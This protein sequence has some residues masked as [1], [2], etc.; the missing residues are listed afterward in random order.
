MRSTLVVR[1]TV[2]A[3]F[4]STVAAGSARAI[5]LEEGTDHCTTTVYTC[6]YTLV[7]GYN[8]P[9]AGNQVTLSLGGSVSYC[10]SDGDG[11]WDTTV[12]PGGGSTGY[13]NSAGYVRVTTA[14]WAA[15]DRVSPACAPVG[16]MG[17]K[18]PILRGGPGTT[19]LAGGG[20]VA[21]LPDAEGQQCGFES[22]CG[23]A[24]LYTSR[25]G[26]YDRPLVVAEGFDPK[27]KTSTPRTADRYWI[28][29][30]GHPDNLGG[31]P[32][33]LLNRLS[34]MGYDVWLVRPYK[35]GNNL[36]E[37]AA[38][39]A[40]AIARA[41]RHNGLNRKVIAFGYSLGGIVARVATARWTH[42]ASWRIS[43]G[44]QHGLPV[45]FILA[46]DAALRGAQLPND[47]QKFLW[48]EGMQGITNLDTCGAQQMAQFSY[49]RSAY[50]YL[51]GYYT[52]PGTHSRWEKFY[53][54][55]Q[56]LSF[57]NSTGGHS[58]Q[59]IYCGGGPAATR[60]GAYGDGW[61]PGVPRALLAQGTISQS[62]RCYGDS[63]DLNGDGFNVCKDTAG[64]WVP[65]AGSTYVKAVAK[66]SWDIGFIS[67]S[68]TK[69][70]HAYF[71]ANQS[72]PYFYNND[73]EPG[74]RHDTSV[75]AL[76]GFNYLS[77]TGTKWLIFDWELNAWIYQYAMATFMPARTAL[78]T[79]CVG[80]AAYAPSWSND[81]NATHR[82]ITDTPSNAGGGVGAASW[83]MNRI[84][85]TPV[86]AADPAMCGDYV[87]N[88][89]ESS[90][91][92]PSDCGA[93]PPQPY[94]GDGTC[95][96][97][98]GEDCYWCSDCGY[99]GGC[100]GPEIC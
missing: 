3:C 60:Q 13:T 20:M 66:V 5:P 71:V 6:D 31:W 40:Q 58:A 97:G 92:C 61:A 90:Y 16:R 14:I 98:Y 56:S 10:D 64:A 96:W 54:L 15:P 35:T 37:Q 53:H 77:Q 91:S 8:R 33:T 68:K 80:C 59:T 43:L 36:H 2:V 42:D 99:C 78:D 12:Y 24:R 57:V 23:S 39:Y 95:D 46:A 67:G 79:A 52:G 63:R 32:N 4:A 86:Q 25:D 100:G 27:E 81:F 34:T 84:G 41:S 26:V 75:Q 11:Q 88:G 48:D 44:L 73:L 89:P 69:R 82:R 87:C 19:Y 29:M 1:A 45:N 76:L 62:N 85:E 47:F 28:E 30:N 50:H 65:G 17:I 94:C 22:G 74:S 18:D 7:D 83:M 49:D 21:P 55:G 38:E 70:K 93:P 51:I 9:Q 72:A